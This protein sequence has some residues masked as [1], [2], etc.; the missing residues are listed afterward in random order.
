MD[1]IM[2]QHQV[3]TC[4]SDSSYRIIPNLSPPPN[5]RPPPY[6]STRLAYDFRKKYEKILKN[7]VNF[8][9]KIISFSFELMI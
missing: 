1:V 4:Y 6:F 5:Y 7:P 2:K 3:E 8:A 9:V